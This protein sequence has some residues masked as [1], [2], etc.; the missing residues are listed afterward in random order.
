LYSMVIDGTPL[1][2]TLNVRTV[3]RKRLL[4]EGQCQ[5]ACTQHGV[6]GSV[7]ALVTVMHLIRANLGPGCLAL[8]F[9]F[10]AAGW[11]W[12]T[13]I[14]VITIAQGIYVILLLTHCKR[15]LRCEG[16]QNL[17]EVAGWAY[18]RCGR[19]AVQ[20][21]LVITQGG[22]CCVYVD[23]ISSN[24]ASIVNANMSHGHCVLILTPI[25]FLL[26]LLKS[27]EKLTIYSAIGN[28]IM[29]ITIIL[30]TLR[31]G[32]TLFLIGANAWTSAAHPA[33]PVDVV[34][35]A[36]NTFFTFEG[37]G[38]V[39]P[40]ENAMRNP[41]AF[42]QAFSCA[43]MVLLGA[44]ISVGLSCG[45]AFNG[46]ITSGPITSFLVTRYSGSVSG[47]ILYVVNSFVTL[48]IL[49]TFPLQLLPVTQVFDEF[50]SSI[51]PGEDSRGTVPDSR[52]V[53]DLPPGESDTDL[54][55]S[56]RQTSQSS[57]CACHSWLPPR[58]AVQ[59]MSVVALTVL[60]AFAVPDVSLLQSFFGSIGQAGLAVVSP[61]CHLQMLRKNWTYG[62]VSCAVLDIA[63]ILFCLGIM[64]VGSTT[65]VMD[66][67]AAFSNHT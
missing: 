4:M 53:A 42:P 61:L 29:I 1:L 48:A 2:V 43:S 45:V 12:G 49:V 54:A 52:C 22:V 58:W 60:I 31:A 7:G 47:T 21:L 37:I 8:P 9:A 34:L 28:V 32:L 6:D 36:A 33:R 63:V 27:V 51:F 44:Y 41:A 35:L 57:S 20:L 15:S 64:V 19:I 18:G 23:L 10:S 38:L 67:Y 66:M 17:E 14:L 40:I 39:L 30:V 62:A 50:I 55:H 56:R 5:R 3:I 24:F 16:V 25:F 65:A 59:N 11:L 46:D 13:P 26:G